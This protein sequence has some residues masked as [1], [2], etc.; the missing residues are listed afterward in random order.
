MYGAPP[1]AYGVA[2]VAPVYPV[3]PVAPVVPVAPVAPVAPAYYP[4]PAAPAAGPTVINLQGNDNSSGG[5]ICPVCGTS[6]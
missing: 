4:S 2:P 6:T 3:A 5:A 1:P